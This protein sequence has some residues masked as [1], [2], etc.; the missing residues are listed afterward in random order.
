[1]LGKKPRVSTET[2]WAG[3]Q[4]GMSTTQ[5]AERYQTTAWN[6]NKRL[7]HAG[8]TLRRVGT[9]AATGPDEVSDGQ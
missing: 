4:A 3:Y 8:H 7:R 1:M 5:L 6:I 9:Y 2:L